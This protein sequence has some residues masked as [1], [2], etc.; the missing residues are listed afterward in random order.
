MPLQDEYTPVIGSVSRRDVEIAAVI[1]A[2]GLLVVGAIL[3]QPVG[4][5]FVNSN[6]MAPTLTTGDAFIAIPAMVTTAPEP[7]EVVTFRATDINSGEL[8]THRIHEETD[9]GYITKGDAN[10]FTDQ[11]AGEP[12][13]TDEQIVAKP[14]QVGPHVVRIPHLGTAIR[15][16]QQ[17]VFGIGNGLFGVLGLDGV[18]TP[19][20]FQAG[21]AATGVG[22]LLWSLLAEDE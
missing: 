1:L 15:A 12:P 9:N 3:G 13:V 8:T 2:F 10:L 14:L 21:L 22:M 16:F 11:S 18:V 7:G 5:A 6:S 17:A 19:R 4:I 20:R